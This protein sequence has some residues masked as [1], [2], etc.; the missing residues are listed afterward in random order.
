MPKSIQHRREMLYTVCSFF[1][2]DI[3]IV[4]KIYLF[5]AILKVLMHIDRDI[6]L[7]GQVLGKWNG[8]FWQ[9]GGLVLKESQLGVF[10]TL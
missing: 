5:V 6:N 8:E 1:H 10:C 9:Y 3:M 4:S 7:L 2:Y